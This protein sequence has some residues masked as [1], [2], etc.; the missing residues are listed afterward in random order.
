MAYIRKRGRRWLAEISKTAP[1]G[2]LI[3]EAS[4]HDTKA[5]AMAWAAQREQEIGGG[6]AVVAKRVTF[7]DLLHR[8]AEEVSTTK[9]GARWEQLR[10]EALT[11]GRPEAFPPVLPDPIASVRLSDLDER[12][13][14]AWR[15][16]R[17]RLVTPGTVRREWSLLSNACTVAIN[18]W[19]LLERHPMSRV[20]HTKGNE[21][22]S[23]RPTTEEI[24]ALMHCCGYDREAA[25]ATMTARVG[26]AILFAV[27][28]AM[29]AGE[30]CGLRWQDVEMARRFVR[31]SGK[32]PAARREVPLSSE[33][34]RILRQLAEV[35]A[36]DSVFQIG[37][38]SLDAL[39][40]KARAKAAIDDL[41][42]HDL[43]HE[44]ITRLAKR[45][46]VLELA[47]AVGHR[48]L[49]MLQIYYNESAEDIAKRLE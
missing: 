47:R 26:A 22:R 16:R 4:S 44:A 37:S 8:Y 27:E 10:I 19:R 32:T 30:I 9:R 15:D 39:Y 14:A 36:G 41:H 35:R 25:P 45:L 20:A 5:E 21:P 40:R 34:L 33:A 46:H 28:T 38:A 6:A 18:E 2:A 3:R 31:T 1:D 43:R 48:D 17:L 23:R 11:R 49:R 24:D 42:F 7:G 12:H 13:F 29:R